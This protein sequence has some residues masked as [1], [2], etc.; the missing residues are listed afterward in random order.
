ME[1]PPR[2]ELGLEDLESF[3]LPLHHRAT[4]GGEAGLHNLNM[5]EQ[6]LRSF[7]EAMK[8]DPAA[9]QVYS[10]MLGSPEL[11]PSFV[12]GAAQHTELSCFS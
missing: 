2:L 10:E 9:Y 5:A 3:V 6:Y 12:P 8:Q 7:E 1:A 11:S 4:S